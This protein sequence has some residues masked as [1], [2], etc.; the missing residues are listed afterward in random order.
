M[1]AADLITVEVV[2]ALPEQ[3][4]VVRLQVPVGTSVYEAARL[5][6]LAERF[7][8]VLDELS[9]GVF[10]KVEKAPR[11]RVLREGERVE[12]YRPLLIDPKVARQARADKVRAA[13]AKR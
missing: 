7:A 11:E 3:Q 4:P 6:G 9:L 10:S 13:K 5:S 1:A 2:Y 8:L 12:I